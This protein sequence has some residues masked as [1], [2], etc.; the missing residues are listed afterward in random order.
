MTHC[1][2]GNNGAGHFSQVCN[3]KQKTK[4]WKRIK[5]IKIRKQPV[6]RIRIRS[7]QDL[8]GRIRI[9]L[10]LINE[11][12]LLNFLI[13][14]YRY[15]APVPVLFR[16]FSAKN[17]SRRKLQKF[18]LVPDPDVFESQIRIRIRSKIVRIRNAASSNT[19]TH[20]IAKLD[21]TLKKC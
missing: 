20:F 14:K 13:D 10:A 12:L 5:K 4:H 9:L 6:F 15:W 21:Q 7:D 8:F 16:A 3:R 11:S 17:I 1:W 19:G 2:P 18:Y